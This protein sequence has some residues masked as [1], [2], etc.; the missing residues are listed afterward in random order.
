MKLTI[1][2]ATGSIGQSTLDLVRR[3][4]GDLQVF[5]LTCANNIAQ[6]VVDANEFRA[7]HVVTS[8]PQRY[9]ALKEAL[10]GTDITAHA[11]AQALLD[12]AAY[13]VDMVVSA[14]VGAAGVAPSLAA[15]KAG[16]D[17]ALANKETMV[18]AGALAKRIAAA[19]GAQI[20]PVDSEHSALAQL[21]KDCAL[22]DVHHVDITASG[23]AFL[24]LTL[25]EMRHVTPEQAATHPNWDMGQRITIDSAS[26]FNKALEIIEAKELFDLT[27]SQINVVV[28]PQSIIHAAVHLVDGGSMLHM[29]L[30]DMRHAISY[31]LRRGE[32]RDIGLGHASLIELGDLNFFAPDVQ[33]YPAIPL[34]YAVMEQGGHCGAVFN[35]AKEVA[36]DAFIAKEIPFLTMSEVVAQTLE[37]MSRQAEI[38]NDILDVKSVL[39]VN[40]RARQTAQ[41]VIASGTL[42]ID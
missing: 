39:E 6:A 41:R 7:A 20:L 28:H 29:G 37:I 5:A 32:R 24:N 26:L 11:G 12:V 27:P 4:D 3:S 16:N 17:V 33:K 34:A 19:S 23:G 42:C 14:I 8:D 10:A 18:C 31:A 35:A 21:L 22:R 25:D 30:P 36:L 15:L 40:D 9:G 38:T 1:L 2:G 13:D